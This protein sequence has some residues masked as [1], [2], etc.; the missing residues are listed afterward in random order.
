M[1]DMDG[2]KEFRDAYQKNLDAFNETNRRIKEGISESDAVQ[3]IKRMAEFTTQVD[4][5]MASDHGAQTASQLLNSIEFLCL[6]LENPQEWIPKCRSKYVDA[7]RTKT[8][9]IVAAL[10]K[11]AD[12]IHNLTGADTSNNADE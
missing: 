6:S 12:T 3:N 7:M 1:G 2:S 4:G 5:S 9:P 11:T 10:R 8:A